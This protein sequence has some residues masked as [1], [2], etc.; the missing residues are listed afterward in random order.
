MSA[1]HV[2]VVNERGERLVRVEVVDRS[3]DATAID[4]SLV[5]ATRDA[6]VLLVRNRRRSVW[7]LPGGFV[8][9]GE[10]AMQSAARELKEE[11]GQT[12]T[13]LRLLALLELDIADRDDENN[14]ALK[15]G[16][17]YHAKLVEPVPFEPTPEIEAIGFWP[18]A[19]LPAGTSA[20]DAA[21]LARFA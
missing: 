18:T 2:P 15:R 6:C 9:A 12:G 10:S 11:T 4:F 14:A 3:A 5:I 17:L 8:D 19:N 1:L 21:L 20:I 16:A 7:E 13:H